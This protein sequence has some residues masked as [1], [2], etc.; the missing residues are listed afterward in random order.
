[1]TFAVYNVSIRGK[2]RN[3]MKRK[4]IIG[5]AVA[6]LICVCIALNARILEPEVFTGSW[7][8]QGDGVRYIFDDGMI[9]CADHEVIA[10]G[11]A[12]FSGAYS[13]AKDRAAIFVVDDQGVGEVVELHLVHRSTGDVLCES[14][15]GKEIIWFCRS[16][17]EA[18]N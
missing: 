3:Y 12:V 15:D 18:M 13:F 17:D 6:A 11:D 5:A 2:R 7:Y 10:L 8:R 14:K 1:M 16:R 9:V 4:M